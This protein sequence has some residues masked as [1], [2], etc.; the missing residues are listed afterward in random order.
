MN[1]QHPAVSAPVFLTG[2][3]RIL[4]KVCGVTV[5]GQ[6]HEIRAIGADLLGL[7]FHPP[8][9]RCVSIETAREIVRAW[10]DPAS[11]VGVFVD[12]KAEEV[13][14]LCRAAGVGFAQLHGDESAETV[15][16]VARELPVIRAFRI[17]D[18][19]AFEAAR[20]HLEEVR[21]RGGSIIAALIDGY[22]AAAHGG[23][24]VTLSESLVKAADSLYPR[25]V[26]AGG[27]NPANLAERLAWIRPWAVDVA[28]GVEVSPGL[29][30]T[31]AVAA[32]LRTLS[33]T[34]KK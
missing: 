28:S 11:T 33:A 26:L 2:A 31:N 4:L 29:K 16:V 13:L 17:K 9:P 1:D 21:E 30:D 15:A 8:S 5:P 25:L 34:S 20:H 12:R 10:G 19:A 32:M 27:L 24:G 23:T 3:D 7:N 14:S 22:S 18:E 6:G